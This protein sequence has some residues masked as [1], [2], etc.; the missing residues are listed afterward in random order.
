MPG[1]GVAEE[2]DLPDRSASPLWFGSLKAFVAAPLDRRLMFCLD[3]YMPLVPT[4]VPDSWSGWPRPRELFPPAPIFDPG[5]WLTRSC[6][7]K[8]LICSWLLRFAVLRWPEPCLLSAFLGLDFCAGAGSAALACSSICSSSLALEVEELGRLLPA[9]LVADS[10][11]SCP[12]GL[13]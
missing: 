7:S 13:A 1:V 11:Y 10:A 9:F 3:E 5:V 12:R 4:S 2:R 8:S 6:G